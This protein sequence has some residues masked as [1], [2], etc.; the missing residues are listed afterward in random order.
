VTWPFSSKREK[1]W[2]EGDKGYHF[3]QKPTLSLFP[4]RCVQSM[5]LKYP[6]ILVFSA[7]VFG[8]KRIYEIFHCVACEKGRFQ[9]RSWGE[10]WAWIKPVG[11]IQE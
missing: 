10:I 5:I 2:K 7:S 6:R 9:R 3:L 8:E 11:L 1:Y 4:P